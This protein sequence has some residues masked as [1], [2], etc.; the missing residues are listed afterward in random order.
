[1]LVIVIIGLIFRRQKQLAV[2]CSNEEVLLLLQAQAQSLNLCAR[3]IQDAGRT[4]VSAGSR[5]VLGIGPGE[6]GD[7][8]RLLRLVPS[9][10][11]WLPEQVQNG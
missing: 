7:L 11:D 8:C 3:T 6:D 2:C 10:T 9:L 4:Q 1:M 5:T